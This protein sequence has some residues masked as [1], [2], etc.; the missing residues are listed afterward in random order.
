MSLREV[1]STHKFQ[2]LRWIR[3][4]VAM[5]LGQNRNANSFW[6]SFLRSEVLD[7]QVAAAATKSV[8]N[9]KVEFYGIALSPV[10]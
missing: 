1:R 8:S 3:S 9:S 10:N 5:L 4:C 6:P 7:G 2:E